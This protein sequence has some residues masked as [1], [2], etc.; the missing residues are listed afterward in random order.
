MSDDVPLLVASVFAAVFTMAL[1][2]GGLSAFF[3]LRIQRGFKESCQQWEEFA[4]RRGLA[5]QRRPLRV[6][7][8]LAGGPI[9]I[10]L[11]AV[12][13]APRTRTV[14]RVRAGAPQ[15]RVEPEWLRVRPRGVDGAITAWAASAGPIVALGDAAFNQR[16]IT[17]TTDAARAHALLGGP[18][19]ARL[20]SFPRDVTLSC[21][22]EANMLWWDGQETELGVLDEACSIVPHAP[23]S[24]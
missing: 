13:S 17:H 23:H 19:G 6:S 10:G 15:T 14:T 11:V 18:L 3:V 4:R 8:V 21:T 7:G 1:V 20:A 24:P 2:V 22:A 12:S 9:T 5:F 16:F